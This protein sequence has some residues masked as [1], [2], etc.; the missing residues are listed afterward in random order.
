[1]VISRRDDLVFPWETPVGLAPAAP[2]VDARGDEFAPAPASP[3]ADESWAEPEEKTRALRST[4][5]RRFSTVLVSTAVVHAVAI[6]ALISFQ[7]IKAGSEAPEPISVDLVRQMPASG[8]PPPSP[9]APVS[10]PQHANPQP[11]QQQPP[12][13]PPPN[14]QPPALRQPP[15]EP[16]PKRA[17]DQR[18]PAPP[19]SSPVLAPASPNGEIAAASQQRPPAPQP[20]PSTALPFFSMP[21]SFTSN[22]LEGQGAS[23][24]QNYKGIVFGKIGGARAFP[25]SAR[26]NHETGQA[27]VSFTVGDNGEI[28]AISLAQSSGFA[29]LDAEAM[30]MVKRVAPFPPP[31]A[32]ADRTFAAAIA[33]GQE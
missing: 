4:T 9:A 11:Q 12:R 33:F 3:A 19:T 28:V 27:I 31:P 7:T 20:E 5:R 22:I 26:A 16:A 2:E 25:D 14:D 15:P 18:K 8:A 10:S 6:L 21:G 13:T 17:V 1:M 24:N 29:D 30:A 32:S 23:E